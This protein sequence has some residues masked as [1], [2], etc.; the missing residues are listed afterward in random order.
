MSKEE[1]VNQ[2]KVESGP[3]DLIFKIKR[4]EVPLDFNWNRDNHPLIQALSGHPKNP[5]ILMLPSEPTPDQILST[6]ITCEGLRDGLHGVSEYPSVDDMFGYVEAAQELGLRSLTVGI[7]PGKENKIDTRIRQLLAKMRNTDVTPTVLLQAS[8]EALDWGLE[9]KNINPSLKGLIFMGTGPSRMLVQEWTKD[10]VLGKLAWAV[11]KATKNDMYVIGATEHT[12]QTEPDFLKQIINTQ[13]E[14]GAKSFCAA[15]TIGIARPVGVYRLITFIKN[16]LEE[17]GHPE[18]SIEWHGHRDMGN[19]VQNAMMAISAGATIIHTVPRGIGERAGNTQLEAVLLNANTI[20]EENGQKGRWNLKKLSH[21]LD[22]YN[23][24]VHVPVSK[25]GPLNENSFHTSLG[26][27][28]DAINKASQLAQEADAMGE[29]EVAKRLRIT[30]ETVYSAI[31]P[32]SVGKRQEVGVGP[33][34][35]SSTVRLAYSL[36]HNRDQNHLT[37]EKIKYI[38][39]TAKSLG[40][41][42]T[43]VELNNLFQNGY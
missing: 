36:S 31:A 21:V 23:Q 33:W 19:D 30:G 7:Y 9:C 42:L 13:V 12:T 2:M 22:T 18:V 26:I 35:G 16:H 6:E 40:R 10:F 29:H 24:M 32:E 14:N 39:S 8:P 37:E 1:E 34:S 15:D 17:I 4:G 41:E 43:P 28:T 11:E 5:D 25:H 20:L 3:K 38:L 27:H